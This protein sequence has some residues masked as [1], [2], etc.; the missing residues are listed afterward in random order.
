MA[1]RKYPV[2]HDK[3]IGMG[4]KYPHCTRETLPVTDFAPVNSRTGKNGRHSSHL[5]RLIY[6][7]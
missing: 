5:V 3:W 1:D 4:K 6:G 7:F 2:W